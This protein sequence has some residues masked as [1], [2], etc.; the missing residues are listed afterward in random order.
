MR[1][2]RRGDRDVLAAFYP[3]RRVGLVWN[4][5]AGDQPGSPMSIADTRALWAVYGVGVAMLPGYS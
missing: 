4:P 5:Y 2:Q 3:P 1:Q